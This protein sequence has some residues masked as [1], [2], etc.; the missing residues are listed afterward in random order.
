[1]KFFIFSSSVFL[2]AIL[3]LLPV[4]AQDS[5]NGK[6]NTDDNF[7]WFELGAGLIVILIVGGIY[8]ATKNKK[9]EWKKELTQPQKDNLNKAQDCISYINSLCPG[10]QMIAAYL[11]VLN[12]RLDEGRIFFCDSLIEE[13]APNAPAYTDIPRIW[14]HPTTYLSECFGNRVFDL[15]KTAD[16]LDFTHLLA[17]LIHESGHPTWDDPPGPNS[18]FT[19]TANILKY[20]LDCIA[21]HKDEIKQRKN[22]TEDTYKMFIEQLKI[23]ESAERNMGMPN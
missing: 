14:G 7:S 20:M 17:T 16:I 5:D 13:N 11:Q 3:F 12:I 19:H 4:Y 18:N 2:F 10:N 9:P 8:Y 22:M 21:Q 6:K 1:V 23:Q 15:S